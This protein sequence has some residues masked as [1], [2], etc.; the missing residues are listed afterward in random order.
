MGRFNGGYKSLNEC[1]S[2][3]D[4]SEM[5]KSYIMIDPH[6]RFFQNALSVFGE[7]DYRYSDRILN[8]GVEKAFSQVE[9]SVARFAS[10]YSSLKRESAA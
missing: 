1:M 2:V 4:N 10:R 5:E 8:V 7:N 9:F 6:G 3:E